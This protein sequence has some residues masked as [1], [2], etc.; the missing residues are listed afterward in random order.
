MLSSALNIHNFIF[1]KN[2][3]LFCCLFITNTGANCLTQ[4]FRNKL[5]FFAAANVS[6]SF[7]PPDLPE[8]A[9]AGMDFNYYSWSFA[10]LI[11]FNSSSSSASFFFFLLSILSFCFGLLF[12]T[13]S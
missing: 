7:P 4:I 1:T 5:T 2:C 6:S 3:W 12:M 11:L 13:P 9:F 8:I 10:S